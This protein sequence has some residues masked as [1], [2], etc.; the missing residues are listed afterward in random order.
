MVTATSI[1]GLIEM[2]NILPRAGFEP[3]LLA[4]WAS[5]LDHLGS[6]MPP[7]Y[8]CLPVYVVPSN[9]FNTYINTHT[10]WQFDLTYTITLGRYNN[11]RV[12]P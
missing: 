1:M 5:V 9:F 12:H 6:L 4:F 2:T 11:H 3:T 10:Y 7:P 8:S